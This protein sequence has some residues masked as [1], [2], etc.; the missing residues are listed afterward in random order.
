MT[1][2]V[3]FH[4]ACPDG[5]ISALA[6][7]MAM[8]GCELFPGRYGRDPPNVA[9]RDVLMFDFAYPREITKKLIREAKTL[10]IIDHHKTAMEELSDLPNCIFDMNRSGAQMAW[11]FF[12]PDKTRPIMFDMIGDAD[13]WRF[14]IEGTREVMCVSEPLPLETQALDQWRALM[15]RI[16]KDPA[17]VIKSGQEIL[18]WKSAKIDNIVAH[19]GKTVLNGYTVP[20]C[21]ATVWKSEI[22]NRLNDGVPFS[23][24]WSMDKRGKIAWSLR[25]SQDGG[26][27]VSVI[28]K[29][30]GG[31]G[32]KHAASFITDYPPRM[33]DS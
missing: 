28:A 31:G 25:S 27:D 13:L 20:C 17:E 16:E 23:I 22:A 5:L 4:A 2:L 12:F 11:D 33:L 3:I 26:I 29:K 6:A 14:A 15:D 21:N 24:V 30:N 9:G 8:P 19:A 10:Q 32:H 7:T 18:K 1:P